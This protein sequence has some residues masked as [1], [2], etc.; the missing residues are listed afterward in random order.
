MEAPEQW[1]LLRGSDD[2]LRGAGFS[3]RARIGSGA[4]ELWLSIERPDGSWTYV[5]L[6]DDSIIAEHA[7]SKREAFLRLVETA[8]ELSA[9][10]PAR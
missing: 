3:V 6:R 9:R 1:G 4:N 7:P 2:S 10:S 5:L 8:S